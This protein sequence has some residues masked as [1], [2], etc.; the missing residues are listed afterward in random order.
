MRLFSLTSVRALLSLLVLPAVLAA[1]TVVRVNVTPSPARVVA[2]ESLQ[3]KAQPV[4]KDGKPVSG[5]LVLFQQ[6]DFPFQGTV[7]S[8]GLV[9]A[10]SVS[11]IPVVVSAI[12][13]GA[14]PV[15][16]RIEVKVVPG[17]AA[18]IKVSPAAL[19]LVPRQS[20]NV[21]AQVF[22]KAGD[23]R[24]DVVTWKSSASAIATVDRTGTVTAVAPGS[25]TITAAAGGVKQPLAVNVIAT[26]VA[27]ASLTP[28]A[29]R[30]RTGDV[31]M[32]K[33]VAKDAAGQEIRGLTPTWSF[34]PGN[35]AID[36]DGGFVGYDAGTY[37]VT[38]LLGGNVAQT[39]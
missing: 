21:G 36:A 15:I 2:G 8:T 1:Q 33:A 10:G 24:S 9:K 31:I 27:S 26:P 35:G 6:Q 34:A 11:T 39:T 30:A 37:S 12:Q 19:K 13:P 29:T 7:D 16:T 18:T 14:K 5:V 4:D 28:S 3:L 20:I 25:A 23:T 17:P 32:F 38:A 22:S